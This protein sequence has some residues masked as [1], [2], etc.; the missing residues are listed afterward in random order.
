MRARRPLPFVLVFLA[1]LLPLAG[2]S[3][4]SPV[5]ARKPPEPLKEEQTRKPGADVFWQDGHWAWSGSKQQYY[6]VAGSWAQEQ[7]G[8][9]WI[10]GYWEPVDEQGKRLGWRWTE[11]R[12]IRQSEVGDD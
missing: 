6:W 1:L 9:V 8:W 3:A 2:C 4:T 10:P 5:I 12:W 7:R 11:P